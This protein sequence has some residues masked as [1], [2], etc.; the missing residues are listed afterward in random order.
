MT[1][2][3]ENV[4]EKKE[5]C[6]NYFIRKGFDKKKAEQIANEYEE[7]GLDFPEELILYNK[8]LK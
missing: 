5:M 7:T 8:I 3:K 4:S 6:V 2:K 1:N